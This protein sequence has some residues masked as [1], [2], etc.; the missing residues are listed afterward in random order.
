MTEWYEDPVFIKM[1]DCPEI[2]DKK[3]EWGEKW[4][5]ELY[6]YDGH[7]NI[8][9]LPRQED[10]QEMAKGFGF[11]GTVF[12]NDILIFKLAEFIEENKPVPQTMEQLWLAF[13]MKTLHN[14]KWDG[15]KWILKDS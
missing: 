4:Y 13:V 12:V 14:K 11:M 9:W 3:P 7:G 6:T 2:Q 10:L 15:E 8:I 5:K 1:C